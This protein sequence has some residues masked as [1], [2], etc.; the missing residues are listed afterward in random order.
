MMQLLAKITRLSIETKLIS[1]NDLFTKNENE[2]F[3]HFKN[4][5]NRELLELINTF[6][7][8]KKEDIP[9]TKIEKVKVRSLYPLVNGRRI[10]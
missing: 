6:E 9:S 10:N 5:N 8:I 3:N 1:Y 2:L 7:S 4:D